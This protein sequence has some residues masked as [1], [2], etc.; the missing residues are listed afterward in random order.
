[1]V[2]SLGS[3][4]SQTRSRPGRNE[5]D[6]ADLPPSSESASKP[7]GLDTTLAQGQEKP[8]LL[9]VP[10]IWKQ[11]LP[12]LKPL[13][14][15]ERRA[16]EIELIPNLAAAPET[17]DPCSYTSQPCGSHDMEP[18][19]P[20]PGSGSAADNSEGSGWSGRLKEAALEFWRSASLS[21]GLRQRE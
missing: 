4:F 14:L 13:G 16:W 10:G 19:F 12:H 1:M 7:V 9:P 3:P 20:R 11:G 6:S 18:Q 15:P 2:G 8:A 5:E 21:A 17:V